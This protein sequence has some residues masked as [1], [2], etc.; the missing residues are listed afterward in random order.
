MTADLFAP[1]PR[2]YVER[3]VSGGQTGADRAGLD[4]AR[5]CGLAHGGWVPSGRWAEDG[6]IDP[7][8]PMQETPL[9]DLRQRTTWN[10]RDSEGTVIF[11]QGTLRGGS[12][13][14]RT[15]ARRLGKPVL[16]LNLSRL[17]RRRAEARLRAWL[18]RYRPR[19]LNIAGSRASQAP[20]LY[21]AVL[22]ILATV[23][24]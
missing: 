23:F 6:P 21:A 1:G 14:T 19:V 4:A 7:A 5:A 22:E 18:D 12:L 16:V 9:R 24:G 3:I 13:L 15:I 20:T 10:V 17:S 11:I 2:T 8:Y